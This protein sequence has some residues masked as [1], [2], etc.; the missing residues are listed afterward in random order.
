M[1]KSVIDLD[2][3]QIHAALIKHVTHEHIDRLERTLLGRRFLH[4]ETLAGGYNR[5]RQGSVIHSYGD[6]KVRFG[7]FQEIDL[8]LVSLRVDHNLINYVSVTK[9]RAQLRPRL[10]I[11]K[12]PL[13]G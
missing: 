10:G 12:F 8:D 4:D 9:I 5:R 11:P 2:P 6:V 13:D 1:R 3:A 7:I